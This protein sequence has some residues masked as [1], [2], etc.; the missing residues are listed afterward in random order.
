MEG[1]S[2]IWV[3]PLSYAKHCG[4]VEN[5]QLFFFFFF[6]FLGPHLW[7]VE[8]P[9]E[10]SNQN[11]SCWPKLQPQQWGIR[12]KF[13]TYTTASRKARD[14]THILKDTSWVRN[15]MSCNGNLR[16]FSTFLFCLASDIETGKAK[17]FRS[18]HSWH[19]GTSDPQFM[20]LKYKQ[21]SVLWV[22]FRKFAFLIK[23]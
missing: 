13:A 2:D 19:W 15:L 18:Q 7:H 16:E 9:S 17:C 10:G 8:F 11:C 20:P 21:S 1:S 6:G 14:C 5:S 3:Q 4:I 23:G 12:A 22:I